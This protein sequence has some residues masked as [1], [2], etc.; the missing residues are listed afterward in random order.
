MATP[1][2]FGI[3]ADIA[4]SVWAPLVCL[5]VTTVALPPTIALLRRRAALD[6]P[7]VRSSHS[8]PTPRGGGAAIAVGIVIATAVMPAGVRLPLLVVAAGFGLIGLAEDLCGVGVAIRFG[9]QMAVGAGAAAILLGDEGVHGAPLIVALVGA[10]WITGYANA[11][12]FMDGVNGISGAHALVGGLVFG[13]LGIW[14]ADASLA[15]G[16]AVI[17]AGAAAFLPWNAVHARVFLGDCGSY[18]LGAGLAVLAAYAVMVRVPPEAALAPLAVYLADT[19]WTLQ[20]RMRAG[21]DWM[22]PHRTHVYQRL[23]DL[24]WTHQRVAAATAGIG[25]LVSLL[26]AVSLTGD[27]PVRAI[28]DAAAI[29]VLVAYLRAPTLLR[30][31]STEAAR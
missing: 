19:A 27:W 22:H 23:C 15:T 21:E 16:G 1:V 28:G 14:R 3:V 24:G 6:V 2:S 20:R 31:A 11:F 12:N 8:V 10:V 17:A 25:A 4:V 30:G 9:L 29:V 18:A 26:G 7:S 13:A 5:A